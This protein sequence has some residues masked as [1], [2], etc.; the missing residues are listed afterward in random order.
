MDFKILLERI[1]PTLKVIAR[2]HVFYSF[3]DADDLFQ[4]MCLFLWN[5]YSSG[6]PI[7]INE[8]YI[9]KGC[10]FHILN[11][12][13][14]GRPKAS[15]LSID[16]VITPEGLRLGDMLEDKKTVYLSDADQ[17]LSIDDIKNMGL[18]ENEKAVFSLLLQGNTVRE[19]AEKMGI[20]HVMV[21]KYKKKIVKKWQKKV[22]KTPGNLL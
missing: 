9:I 7:G 4:E 15:I 19:A 8:A 22:T 11:F 1:T 21:V 12:L 14:K 13:R 5:N 2:K 18:T 10:E 6:M 17:N 3:Y 20:S 16:E